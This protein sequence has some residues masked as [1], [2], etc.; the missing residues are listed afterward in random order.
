MRK[1]TWT[2]HK[3]QFVWKSMRV[4]AVETHM[5]WESTGKMPDPDPEAPRVVRAGAIETHIDISQE[6]CCVEI[7]R[8]N[9]AH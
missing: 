8:K 5:A 9:A 2:C 4:G 1:H 6:P 7:E 3:S